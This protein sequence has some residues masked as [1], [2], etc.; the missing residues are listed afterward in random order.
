MIE[1]ELKK[2]SD[3]TQSSESSSSVSNANE[4]MELEDGTTQA[5]EPQTKMS[6]IEKLINGNDNFRFKESDDL[7]ISNIQKYYQNSLIIQQYLQ[8]S[9]NSQKITL[10]QQN[11]FSDLIDSNDIFEKDIDTK[12]KNEMRK[13][14]LQDR[15]MEL[16]EQGVIDIDSEEFELE[17][18]DQ[19]FSKKIE[20]KTKKHKNTRSYGIKQFNDDLDRLIPK[21]LEAT[22][23]RVIKLENGLKK[24]S[25]KY[26]KSKL[27]N[28]IGSSAFNQK[29][30]EYYLKNIEHNKNKINEFNTVSIQN[31][32]PR[33]KK[34]RRNNSAM[35]SRSTAHIRT[36]NDINV[37]NEQQISQIVH[38]AMNDFSSN[39]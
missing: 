35:G 17:P 14:K 2:I 10:E 7:H 5:P 36:I 27:L 19:Q 1:R 9:T 24:F 16:Q 33:K 18:E 38:S 37:G 31:K 4:S 11:D 29:L 39:Q 32:L 12:T 23:Y 8:T 3:Q 30:Q 28:Q 25:S 6:Y 22:R 26:M 34:T 13:K 15:K 21:W 20:I